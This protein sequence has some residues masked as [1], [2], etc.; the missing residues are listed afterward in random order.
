MGNVA[1][2]AVPTGASWGQGISTAF[3]GIGGAVNDL[4]AA[5]GAQASAG[6]YGQAAQIATTN[7]QIAQNSEQ[8][9]QLQIQRQISQVGGSQE[10]ALGMGNMAESGSGLDVM[11]ESMQQGA[12]A[13][14][15]AA[16]Q[17]TIQV[18]GYQQQAQQYQ[19]MQQAANSSAHGSMIAGALNI[20]GTAAMIAAM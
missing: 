17:G 20:V 7:S 15:E 2:P 12:I 13:K 11:R 8:T 3:S 9:N 5:R 1:T 14:S 18:Q 19:Q 6:S 4:Y 10:A 16:Q